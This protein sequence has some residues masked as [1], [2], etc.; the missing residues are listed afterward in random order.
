MKKKIIAILL[1]LV[2]VVGCMPLANAENSSSTQLY[3][4]YGDGMLLQQNETS[5]ISGTGTPGDEIA[6]ELHGENGVIFES[7]AQVKD[8]GTFSVALSAPNG[9]FD[10]YTIILKVNGA[11]FEALENILFGEL[12]LANGQSNM[13]YPLAQAKHGR[14]LY[15]KPEKLDKNLRVLYV[16]DI[17]AYK[18][19]KELVPADPQKDVPGAMWL[20]GEW[21]KIT[22]DLDRIYL[23]GNEGG[24]AY[25][26]ERLDTVKNIKFVFSADFGEDA[27]L[28]LDGIEFTPSAQDSGPRFDPDIKMPITFSK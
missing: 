21:H 17:P 24:I 3:S 19:S 26:N 7:S 5:F 14:D 23:S 20:D 13:Q 11:E 10:E 25:S 15:A 12:W 6:L 28:S 16:P 2:I 9:G 22:L 1:T 27:D 18:G 8:D 4:V